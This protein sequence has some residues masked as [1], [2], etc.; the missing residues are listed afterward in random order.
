VFSAHKTTTMRRTIRLQ[1]RQMRA[2]SGR[3]LRAMIVEWLF[4]MHFDKGLACL[5]RMPPRLVRH[6]MEIVRVSFL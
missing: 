1:I 4:P 5:Q 6:T 2:L 3:F